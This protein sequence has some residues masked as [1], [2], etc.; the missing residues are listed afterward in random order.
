M[1]LAWRALA[2]CRRRVQLATTG[3]RGHASDR[4]YSPRRALSIGADLLTD[5]QRA[6]IAALFTGDEHVQVQATGSVYQATIGAYR[7]RN[8]TAGRTKMC[9]LSDGPSACGRRVGR[10]AADA[11]NRYG[12]IS[13]GPAAGSARASVRQFRAAGDL[14]GP[15]SDRRPDGK[16]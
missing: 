9:E 13:V 4:L 8:R 16:G 12:S 15:G 7:D 14:G 11:E 5:P 10:R 3:H 6:R 2:E 1:R